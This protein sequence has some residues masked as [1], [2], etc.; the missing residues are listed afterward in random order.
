MK[1]IILIIIF[2]FSSASYLFADILVGLNV[3]SMN[4]THKSAKGIYRSP[5]LTNNVEID[6]SENINYYGFGAQIEIG[7][8]AGK[9]GIRIL[10]TKFSS[11]TSV[12][13]SALATPVYDMLGFD[14]EQSNDLTTSPPSSLV[15]RESSVGTPILFK[16]NIPNK[17]KAKTKTL[18]IIRR[19]L[20]TM[21]LWGGIGPMLIT[22]S[23]ITEA[24][25]KNQFSSYSYTDF[26]FL[27]GG[28]MNIEVH[29][30][31]KKYPRNLIISLD[32]IYTKN[33]TPDNSF[34]SNDDN[35]NIIQSGWMINFGV[36]YRL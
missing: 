21:N 18:K 8:L 2:L 9:A 23:R 28:G 16:Y 14:N 36:G 22:T 12:S 19:V 29:H 7:F 10:P 20:R 5:A 24:V 34:S 33:L 27:I 15:I 30:A 6:Y 11:E 17:F 1:K 26:Y 32:L 3:L 4:L 35:L 13:S 31:W 25:N